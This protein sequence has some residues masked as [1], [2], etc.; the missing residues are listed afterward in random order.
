MSYH[1]QLD[2]R[3]RRRRRAAIHRLE[4][5]AGLLPALR[6]VSRSDWL[7]F[8]VRERLVSLFCPPE[9][10]SP[11]PFEVDFFGFRY[12]GD[13]S[14]Y[15][16]W[17]VYFFGAYEEEILFLLRDLLQERSGEVFVDIGANV[18]QHA[19]FMSEWAHTVHAFE[20]WDVVRGAIQEKIERNQVKN[21]TVHPV[22][23]G[24]RH[25]WL[26]YF[27]PLGANT[28]TGSFDK[29]HA[30]DR[31]RLL[32][33][34]EIVNGDEY[35]EAKGFSQI[36]LIKIDVEG[37]E[38]FVLMGLR[39]TLARWKP[40]VLMEVSE[41]TLRTLSG[42]EKFRRC[43]PDYYETVYIDSTGN[44]IRYSRFDATKTGSVLLRA[45]S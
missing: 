9:Y 14:R 16:D 35:F 29:N 5:R 11:L 26:P 44:G 21:I 31:N 17:Y 25:E 27:A 30:I 7:P 4:M 1:H 19:L 34:L 43:I 28:G 42:P 23:I 40:A 3:E 10:S 18:G 8:G 22:G 6:L 33:K 36:D 2:T 15:L 39:E 45:T 13:L 38:Q 12:P 20:P 32:G 24:E 37:W 41:S